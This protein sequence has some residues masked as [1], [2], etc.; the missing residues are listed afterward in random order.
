MERDKRVETITI[1]IESEHKAA[2]EKLAAAD[3]RTLST[4]VARVLKAHL[5]KTPAGGKPR[6]AE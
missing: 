4:Y 3:D 2:L 5:A 6:V 1:R